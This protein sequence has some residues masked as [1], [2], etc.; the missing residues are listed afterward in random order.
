MMKFEVRKETNRK[1]NKNQ[2]QTDQIKM[3]DEMEVFEGNLL[4]MESILNMESIHKIKFFV[5]AC[6]FLSTTIFP[7]FYFS[8]PSISL[9]V[10]RKENEYYYPLQSSM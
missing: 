2:L 6:D 10:E 8:C 1:R 4:Y 9:S 7:S 3:R 5:F